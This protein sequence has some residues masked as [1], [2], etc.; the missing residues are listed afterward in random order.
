MKLPV[1]CLRRRWLLVLLLAPPLLWT[2]VLAVLPTDCARRKIA[3]RLSV[4]SGREVHLGG[5][6]VGWLGTVWLTDLR[7]G[8]PVS[9]DDDPWLRVRRAA[10]NVSLWQLVRGHVEPTEVNIEGVSLRVLR[11]ANGS[12]ELGDMLETPENSGHGGGDPT[13]RDLL[14]RFRDAAVTVIDEPT[15]TR[16]QL[17]G[18]EGKATCKGPIAFIPELTGTINGGTFALAARLDRS[19]AEPRFEGQ[20][21]VRDVDLDEGMHALSYLVP[22]LAGNSAR[23]DGTLSL[24]LYLRGQG[25]T[26]ENLCRSLVGHGQVIL[27]PV[28]LDGSQLLD[29]VGRV[30]DLPPD[31]RAGSIHSSLTVKDGRIASD[32]LTLDVAQVPLV[33]SGWTDFDGRIDYRLRSDRMADRLPARAREFLSELSVRFEE[34]ADVRVKGTVDALEISLDGVVLSQAP[35]SSAPGGDDG[36]KFREFG[37]RLR[38]RIRR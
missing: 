10:I 6:R 8:A 17:L 31:G 4:A 9:L 7:I 38:D 22:A 23:S 15:R 20:I 16:L 5:V 29:Q 32:D 2:L 36:A 24:D 28:M 21:K 11:R 26:R 19:E 37:R 25:D 18:V 33:L 13:E 27:D 3:T 30:V 35:G 1:Q 12:L 14:V 34:V